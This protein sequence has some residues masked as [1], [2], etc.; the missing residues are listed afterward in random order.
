MT[1]PFDPSQ[2]GQSIDQLA[3]LTGMPS[4]A[5]PKKKTRRGRRK[6]RQMESDPTAHLSAARQ[7]MEAGDHATAKKH[8]FALVRSL[9]AKAPP[10]TGTGNLPSAN[11]FPAG[12]KASGVSTPPSM[13]IGSGSVSP[14]ATTALDP[15]QVRASRLV[16]ALHAGRKK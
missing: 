8:A 10:M 2:S 9:H 1:I 11:P 6:G 15:A 13:A 16:H 7:A 3:S 4:G 5:S 14:K 12:I